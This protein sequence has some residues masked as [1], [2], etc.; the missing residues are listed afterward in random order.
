MDLPQYTHVICKDL[1]KWAFKQDLMW[2]IMEEYDSVTITN[3]KRT[4]KLQP[5]ETGFRVEVSK[6][7]VELPVDLPAVKNLLVKL[8]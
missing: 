7:V 1:Q 2:T 3:S 8:L 5:L 6:K 4:V